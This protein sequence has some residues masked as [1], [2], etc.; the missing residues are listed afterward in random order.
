ME[1]AFFWLKG[2]KVLY[3]E[4]LLWYLMIIDY[5]SI[6]ITTIITNILDNLLIR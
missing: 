3:V 2:H 5:K 4:Y 6:I 1:K